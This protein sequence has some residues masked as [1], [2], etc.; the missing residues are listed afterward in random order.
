MKMKNKTKLLAA[1]ILCLGLLTFPAPLPAAVGEFIGGT[2]SGVDDHGTSYLNGWVTGGDFSNLFATYTGGDVWYESYAVDSQ[3]WFAW[4]EIT[5]F[6]DPL[7]FTTGSN[8]NVYT[9]LSDG[10]GGTAM[11]NVVYADGVSI[12]ELQMANSV[13]GFLDYYYE[14]DDQ[15]GNVGA[16][17][18]EIINYIDPSGTYSYDYNKKID[19]DDGNYWDDWTYDSWNWFEA[20]TGDGRVGSNFYNYVEGIRV[21]NDYD[22]N[23][24]TGDFDI[25]QDSYLDTDHDG[26][27]TDN[28]YTRLDESFDVYSGEYEKSWRVYDFDGL[29]T[30]AASYYREYDYENLYSGEFEHYVDARIDTD[31]DGSYDDY[32]S[33]SD[34]GA[35]RTYTENSFYIDD[36]PYTYTTTRLYDSI[37]R[38][39]SRSYSEVN[40]NGDYSYSDSYYRWDADGDGFYSDDYYWDVGNWSRSG[41]TFQWVRLYDYVSTYANYYEL[42]YWQDVNTGDFNREETTAIDNDGDGYFWDYNDQKGAYYSDSYSG[43]NSEEAYSW[44]GT[45]VWDPAG[46]YDAVTGTFGTYQYAYSYSYA[47]GDSYSESQYAKDTDN[48]GDIE[49]WGSNDLWQYAYQEYD[50]D[51]LYTYSWSEVEEDTANARGAYSRMWTESGLYAG[52][53]EFYNHAHVENLGGLV[54]TSEGYDADDGY[55]WSNYETRTWGDSRTYVENWSYTAGDF[56]VYSEINLDTDA[57]TAWN[58]Q[59]DYEAYA[60]SWDE[61]YSW[62]WAEEGLAGGRYVGSSTCDSNTSDEFEQE[63]AYTSSGDAWSYY[64]YDGSTGN[65]IEQMLYYAS[66]DL[67]AGAG[68]AFGILSYSGPIAAPYTWVDY[69]YVDAANA[70][71][72]VD[73]NLL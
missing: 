58:N 60:E 30:D 57:D 8:Y 72:L 45:E 9:N 40:T 14:Y 61:T 41:E 63:F 24:L 42:C 6:T 71:Y 59:W 33:W 2:T 48:D 49:R 46:D 53:G 16:Y 28:Y 7:N 34:F 25:D 21:Y 36:Y 54:E 12:E 44:A 47:G 43:F 62:W 73:Y 5:A 55:N 52:S 23:S 67:A 15:S 26:N 32:W 50:A 10:A 51:E 19:I 39:Q 37:N 18:E 3:T 13:T 56:G 20:G 69:M 65:E 64:S 22:F 70:W 1:L 66:G 11:S 17:Y 35:Y 29:G 27:W 31:G 68:P 38:V 4:Y